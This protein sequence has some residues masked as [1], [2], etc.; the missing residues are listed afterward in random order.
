MKKTPEEIKNKLYEID[1]ILSGYEDWMHGKDGDDC[2]KAR[3]LLAEVTQCQAD[4]AEQIEHYKGLWKQGCDII[5]VLQEQ[6]DDLEKDIR[7]HK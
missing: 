3:K 5:D 7:S 1:E 2:T 6:I 4:N